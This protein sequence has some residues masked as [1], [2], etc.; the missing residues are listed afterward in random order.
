MKE[1]GTIFPYGLKERCKDGDATKSM[2]NVYIVFNKLKKRKK[3][4]TNNNITQ[5]KR[6]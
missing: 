4:H 5:P 6:I 2:I 3:N 1:L